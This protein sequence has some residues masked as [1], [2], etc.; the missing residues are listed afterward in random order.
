MNNIIDG[1][2]IYKFVD[3]DIKKIAIYRVCNNNNNIIIL[4]I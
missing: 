1:V 2:P 3:F 4:I